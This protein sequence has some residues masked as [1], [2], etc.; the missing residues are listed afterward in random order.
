MPNHRPNNGSPYASLPCHK[1]R[2]DME[3]ADGGVVL[4]ADV[5]AVSKLIVS[6]DRTL[7]ARSARRGLASQ[8]DVVLK[9]CKS[10]SE[11]V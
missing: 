3:I 11:M 8:N 4:G 1:L 10:S 2:I 6:E 7:F 5:L 9:L